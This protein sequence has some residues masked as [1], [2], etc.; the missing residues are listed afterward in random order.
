MSLELLPAFCWAAK[1]AVA[2]AVLERPLDRIYFKRA[3]CA[4]DSPWAE[5]V[6]FCVIS[7]L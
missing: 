1:V 4:L 2:V 5:H 7:P 3:G 6:A